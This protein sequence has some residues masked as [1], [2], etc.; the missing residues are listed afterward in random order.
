MSAHNAAST[1][2]RWDEDDEA[3]DVALDEAVLRFF[4]VEGT[5]SASPDV[6]RATQA[7][8]KS[9]TAAEALNKPNG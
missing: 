5:H 8:T 2:D 7:M 9:L 1:D 6:Q 4:R 3:D